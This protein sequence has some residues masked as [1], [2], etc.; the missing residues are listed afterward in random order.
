MC[1]ALGSDRHTAAPSCAVFLLAR[2]LRGGGALRSRKCL[3][4]G[5]VRR[6]TARE[7]GG[8]EG[9]DAGTSRSREAGTS[10]ARH[11]RVAQ[12]GASIEGRSVEAGARGTARAP[13][14]PLHAL[15]HERLV[16]RARNAHLRLRGGDEEGACKRGRVARI[17]APQISPRTHVE[18]RLHLL[19]LQ[20]HREGAAGVGEWRRIAGERAATRRATHRDALLRHLHRLEARLRN[21][22][23]RAGACG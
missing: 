10:S 6:R 8:G 7:G 23:H 22:G 3:C 15:L 16:L 11:T 13:P 19:R 14:A 9:G 21:G 4:L 18:L 5:D 20:G 17:H 2:C 1:C 12:G